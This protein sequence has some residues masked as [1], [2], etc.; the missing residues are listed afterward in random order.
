MI[1]VGIGTTAQV[2]SKERDDLVRHSSFEVGSQSSRLA[3]ALE[4]QVRERHTN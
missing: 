2:R 1:A 4:T 3:L